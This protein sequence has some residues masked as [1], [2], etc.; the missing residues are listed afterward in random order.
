[1]ETA[2]FHSVNAGLYFWDGQN[3]LLVDAVHE[4]REE[5]LSPMPEFLEKQMRRHSGIFGHL[6]GMLFTH[7]HHDHFDA[8]KVSEIQRSAARLPIYGPNLLDGRVE[9]KIVRPDT[10]RLV[11]GDVPVWAWDTRHDG[12][13]FA[14]TPHQSF[15]LTLSNEHFF[16]AGDAI[17]SANDAAR[18]L[19]SHCGTVEAA[20]CNLYQLASLDGQE[21]LRILSPKQV[22][23]YH[24]PFFEDDTCGYHRLARQVL[25]KYSK[26]LPPVTQLKHMAWL[27][28][29][30]AQ[31]KNRRGEDQ[32]GVS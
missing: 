25:K 3:G 16:V 6:N 31:W 10:Y 26:N 15:L 27:D 20:F 13:A 5:G 17:L 21:F 7:L 30:P 23:L 24:L 18:V 4:G 14:A 1:M 29:K 28:D 32:Y 11:M 2:I 9:L 8:E 12:M 22:F 19:E